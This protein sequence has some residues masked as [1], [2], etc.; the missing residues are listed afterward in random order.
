[1]KTIEV[2]VF[3]SKKKL[4]KVLQKIE[5]FSTCYCKKQ[6][7]F[8]YIGRE[9]VNMWEFVDKTH[10]VFYEIGNPFK[11]E[12]YITFDKE[13]ISN[14][15]DKFYKNNV[16][17]RHEWKVEKDGSVTYKEPI[18]PKV[19]RDKLERFKKENVTIDNIYKKW[20]KILKNHSEAK[21]NTIKAGSVIINVTL[22][23]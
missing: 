23:R 3:K 12:E 21:C 10:N 16:G 14:I 19:D 8:Y 2:K 18:L 7:K 4:K 9:V 1:M 13:T 6:D 15:H 11:N 5:T 20:L 22:E 17:Y